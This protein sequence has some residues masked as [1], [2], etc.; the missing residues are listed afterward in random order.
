MNLRKLQEILEDRGG[1]SAWGS[2]RVRHNLVTE[3]QQINL[4]KEKYEQKHAK[5]H[6]RLKIKEE[7][8]NLKADRRK[9]Q[10]YIK[11]HTV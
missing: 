3:Q 11:E 10:L 2:Q 1:W 6:N 7:K 5:A 8:K 4:K 9:W